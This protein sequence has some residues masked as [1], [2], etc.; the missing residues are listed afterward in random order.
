VTSV[1]FQ[2]ILAWEL[3]LNVRQVGWVP[4]Q[5]ISGG[6]PAVLF[7]NHFAGWQVRTYHTTGSACGQ[8]VRDTP[9][10]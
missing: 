7:T 4:Q 5:W 6:R 2:S 3:G 9:A 10:N 1:P 8:L